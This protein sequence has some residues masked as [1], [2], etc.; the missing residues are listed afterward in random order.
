MTKLPVNPFC[1]LKLISIVV[2]FSFNASNESDRFCGRISSTNETSWIGELVSC[3]HIQAVSTAIQLLPH[4]EEDTGEKRRMGRSND[5]K[6][7]SM[8]RGKRG[9]EQREQRQSTSYEFPR[10]IPYCTILLKRGAPYQNKRTRISCILH[11]C[12][13][14]ISVRNDIGRQNGGRWNDLNDLDWYFCYFTT[15][16]SCVKKFIPC[17]SLFPPTSK[18]V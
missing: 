7:K 6:K 17:H 10:K 15:I 2:N 8:E 11:A 9:L 4:R 3:D 5:R 12:H 18:F 14:T 1:T 16:N 13:D